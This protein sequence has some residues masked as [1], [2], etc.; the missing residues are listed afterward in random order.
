MNKMKPLCAFVFLGIVY[1]TACSKANEEELLQNA[2]G[3]DTVNVSYSADVLPIISSNCYSC[4][5]NGNEEGGVSLEGY[6]NLKFFADNGDLE[7]VITHS[8]GYPAMPLNQPKLSDC[9]INIITAWINA[10]AENN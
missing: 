8:P 10:G 6:D 1:L 4:H 9:E 5:G 3:C 7:G 2:G